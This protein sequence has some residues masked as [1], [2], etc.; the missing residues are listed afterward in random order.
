MLISND[1]EDFFASSTLLRV[2]VRYLPA[3]LLSF[4]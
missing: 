4:L 3:A 2:Y 1:L